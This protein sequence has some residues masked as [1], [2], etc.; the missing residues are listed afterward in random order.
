MGITKW[1]ASDHFS[2]SEL[3]ANWDLVDAHDHTSGKGVQIPTAGIANSAITSAKIA[4][5]AIV[6]ADINASADIDGSKLGAGSIPV[7]RL[8]SQWIT[9]KTVGARF[10][11]GSPSTDYTF[12]PSELFETFSGSGTFLASRIFYVDPADFSSSGKLRLRGMFSNKSGA[13]RLGTS[14]TMSLISVTDASGSSPTAISSTNI[15]SVS[16]DQNKIVTSTSFSPP[17]AKAHYIWCSFP[18]AG[19]GGATDIY[20]KVD[21]QWNPSL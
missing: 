13:S 21:L 1:G 12:T 5:G 2:Y 4:D 11:V 17:T 9:Y 19:L 14:A 20:V 3:A 15:G 18:Q 6:N 8:A 10:N 16:D 7:S